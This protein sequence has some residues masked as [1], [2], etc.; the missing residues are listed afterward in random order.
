[1][2]RKDP[3]IAIYH[4]TVESAAESNVSTNE[5]KK[6]LLDARADTGMLKT[7]GAPNFLA[8]EIGKQLFVFLHKVDSEVNT[9]LA[10]SDLGLDSLIAI[11][12]RTWWKQTFGFDISV[13]EMLGM[14]DLEVLGSHAAERLV[15]IVEEDGAYIGLYMHTPIL[16]ARKSTAHRTSDCQ[17]SRGSDEC[18]QCVVAR[19]SF[20]QYP[21]EYKSCIARGI[22][23]FNHCST[24]SLSG[25]DACLR[26]E[27]ATSCHS[28]ASMV[29]VA[30]NV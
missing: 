8:Q 1:M 5:L 11:K 9:S 24:S 2:W 25:I 16:D 19:I 29:I 28:K 22:F 26:P 15:Q 27:I 20:D 13:L 4:N 12:M 17:H 18:D 6:Y 3:R 21:H 10:L 14:G 30:L 7:P 23:Y